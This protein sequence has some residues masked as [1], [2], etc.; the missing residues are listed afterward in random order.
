MLAGVNDVTTRVV[1]VVVSPVVASAGVLV[2][3]TAVDDVAARVMVVVVAPAAVPA[4]V[5]VM[6]RC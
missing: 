5:T 3:L 1:V 6:R 4:G 2:A